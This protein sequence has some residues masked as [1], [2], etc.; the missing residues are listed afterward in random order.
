MVWD[1]G[2]A[3]EQWVPL[4]YFRHLKGAYKKVNQ[5]RAHH[6]KQRQTR[7]NLRT[8]TFFIEF[9]KTKTVRAFELSPE[10]SLDGDWIKRHLYGMTSTS[11]SYPSAYVLMPSSLCPGKTISGTPIKRRKKKEHKPHIPERTMH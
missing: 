8:P 5:Q 11:W 1:L 3:T 7:V 10:F 9:R 2:K 4:S 6:I